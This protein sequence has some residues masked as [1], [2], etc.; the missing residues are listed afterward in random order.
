[1][2]R[3][4]HRTLH[5]MPGSVSIVIGRS[6]L[7]SLLQFRNSVVRLTSTRS[8]TVWP[9]S[10]TALP[11][12]SVSIPSL[13]PKL[14][15]S[16]PAPYST[17]SGG[18]RSWK[19]ITL[20]T[21]RMAPFV[22]AAAE[23][24][25]ARVVPVSGGTAGEGLGPSPAQPPV[26]VAA[27]SAASR[28]A[29]E[30]PRTCRARRWRCTSRRL[31]EWRA[32]VDHGLRD[33]LSGQ[34]G[35]VASREIIANH[36]DGQLVAGDGALLREVIHS[37]IACLEGVGV[38]R[39]KDAIP[40]NDAVLEDDQPLAREAQLHPGAMA[41]IHTGRRIPFGGGLLLIGETGGVDGRRLLCAGGCRDPGTLENAR[42][43]GRRG[44]W[45]GGD[46]RRG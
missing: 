38:D 37:P 9:G 15:S 33:L 28:P 18:N 45:S 19:G 3:S 11:T 21:T 31:L 34:L 25:R 17:Q 40:S 42:G 29:I 41:H 2:L 32:L 4:P 23:G 46:R 16:A 26:H 8:A 6:R 14:C 20:D 7:A 12:I 24:M 1:M 22:G 44:G 36:V 35:R 30:R 10:I 13:V 39:P 5:R 27:A 43:T